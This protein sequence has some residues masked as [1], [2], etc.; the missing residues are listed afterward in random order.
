MPTFPTVVSDF[1]TRITSSLSQGTDLG[2]DIRGASKSYLRAQDLA[3]VL[4]LLQD[5]MDQSSNMTVVD[6]GVASATVRSFQDGVQSTG[7]LTFTGLA[8]DT[9]TVTIDGKV[10]TF[11][12]TLTN[13]DGNVKIGASAAACVAN[14]VAAIN[15]GAGAG[16]AYAAAMTL[17]PTFSAVDG[18]GDTVVIHAKLSGVGENGSGTTETQTNAAWGAATTSGGVD[19]FPPNSLVGSVVVFGAATTTV[20]LRGAEARIASNTAGKIVLESDLPAVPAVGDVY[21]IRGGLLDAHLSELREGKNLGD[22]PSGSI[23]G[24]ARLVTDALMLVLRR[25]GVDATQTLTFSGVPA[26]TQTVTIDGK[27]YTFKDTLSDTDGFV[28]KD[29]TAAAC[30]ANLAAAITLGAGSGT[31]YAAST[32]LHPTVTA[33]VVSTTV[34]RIRAK[35]AGTSGNS[36]AISETCANVA[37]GGATLLGGLAGGSGP[38]AERNVGHSALQVGTGSTT[39]R[40]VLNTTNYGDFR[41]DQF[42]GMK[43]VVGSETARKIISSDESSFLV[44]PALS[45]APVATT[46]VTITVPEDDKASLL[47]THPGAPPGDNIMLANLITQAVS[48]MSSYVL[49]V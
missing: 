5:A 8:V 30:I 43:V 25:R 36:I 23:Y 49:P 28:K 38:V 29:A 22:S 15:L 16:T 13:V 40:V 37:L 21:T 2:S 4:D 41:I 27:V 39:T 18:A 48:A 1:F 31:A 10:Y 33:D 42:K 32:T 9:Q 6:S 17:H 26:D 11:Q 20:A 14:L 7:T 45:T 19:A 44:A 35:L 3:S 12:D 24:D 34:L 46:A 47:R